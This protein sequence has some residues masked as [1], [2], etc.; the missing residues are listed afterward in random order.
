[1]PTH[2]AVA[3][4]LGALIASSTTSAVAQTDSG[5]L[6]VT[7]TVDRTELHTV[8]DDGTSPRRLGDV[9][10]VL[11][12][13]GWSPDGSRVVFARSRGEPTGPDLWT[14]RADGSDARFLAGTPHA[15]LIPTFSPDGSRVA[16]VAHA[17]TRFLLQVV[18][19]DGSGLRA[20]FDAPF[21]FSYDWAPDSRRIVV[22]HEGGA[23][24]IVDVESGRIERL[25]D[26]GGDWPSW[27]P[28]GK[29][30]AFG[31]LGNQI[32][33]GRLHVMAPDGTG[34]R[35]LSAQPIAEPAAWA[36]DSR[37]LAFVGRRIVTYARYGPVFADEIFS[38]AVDGSHE[39]KLTRARSDEMP[40]WSSDG[41]RIAFTTARDS[42]RLGRR[43]AYVM[44]ADGSCESRVATGVVWRDAWRPGAS[45]SRPAL[46]CADLGLTLRATDRVIRRN[47]RARF[48]VRIR[49]DGNRPA[50][51][52]IVRFAPGRRPQ[53]KL[54]RL[55]VGAVRT[56][57]FVAR[58]HRSGT[59][60]A[61]ATVR[62]DEPDRNRS[63]NAA[64]VTIRRR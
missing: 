28:D 32:A 21:T 6:L 13:P 42:D 1:M 36:P 35:Q 40:S 60:V 7:R 14:M 45:A 31:R 46:E 53:V 11:T 43:A 56:V 50:T 54:G 41:S 4:L 15:D 62:A 57:A 27:S 38:V 9:G 49:N 48:V 24:S 61:R 37:S 29:L 16:F 30:I 64:V 47:R 19:A 2:R 51:N 3:A 18:S 39:R 23:M 55:A 20:L 33:G 59:L 26:V 10:R 52:V 63:D 12:S 8:R 25:P 34:L 22:A 17:T 58:L 44:N 5:T